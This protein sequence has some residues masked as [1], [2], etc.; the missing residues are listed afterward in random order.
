VSGG[1]RLRPGAVIG[2]FQRRKE[3]RYAS[4]D[5]PQFKR[6][7]LQVRI[8]FLVPVLLSLAFHAGLLVAW[9][10][11]VLLPSPGTSASSKPLPISFLIEPIEETRNLPNASRTKPVHHEQ[12]NVDAVD[13]LGRS[14]AKPVIA[15]NQGGEKTESARVAH[16]IPPHPMPEKTLASMAAPPPPTAEEWEMA[17]TYTLKNS[18]RYRYNWGQQ[19]RSMMGTVVE[20]PQQG[21]VRFRIEIAPDGKIAKVETL[22]STSEVA[23]KLARQAIGSLPMLPPTPTGRP[24]VFEQTIAY[25]PFETGWPPIYKY[26]CLPDPPKFHNPFVWDGSS[27][28]IDSRVAPINVSPSSKPSIDGGCPNDAQPDSIEAEAADIKRQFDQ[29]SVRPLNGVD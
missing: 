13:Q 26:D 6:L 29:W 23:E 4:A 2:W 11:R 12:M 15:A 5:A 28:Q 3:Q 27:P 16:S 17:S 22:W 1:S 10:G 8:S 21:L 25:E 14:R 20:G 9:K 18:K 24:L 7:M 19:V